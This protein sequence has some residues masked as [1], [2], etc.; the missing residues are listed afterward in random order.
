MARNELITQEGEREMKRVMKKHSLVVVILF[1]MLA[2]L[3]L[4]LTAQPAPAAGSETAQLNVNVSMADSLAELKGKRVT[5]YLASGQT[6]T[7]VVNDVKGNL[8]HLTQLSQ[9]EFFDALVAIDHISS[10]EAKVR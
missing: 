10:I 4:F 6:L 5:V 7:G 9:K 3:N 2:G 1:A 8:L